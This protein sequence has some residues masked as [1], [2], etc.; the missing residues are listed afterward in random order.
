MVRQIRDVEAA[1][2]DGRKLG[3]A[4][5]EMEMHQ[6]ARRSLVAA[7]PITRGTA[8]AR[9][10]RSHSRPAASTAKK[11]AGTLASCLRNVSLT[12]AASPDLGT[13]PR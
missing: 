4:P 2:G 3:P 8:I 5:E 6:K 10:S 1:L 12:G 11:S 9:V 13:Q 7:R